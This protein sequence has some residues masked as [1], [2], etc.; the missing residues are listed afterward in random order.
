MTAPMADTREYLV[1][2]QCLRVTLD[3]FVDA[4]AR[5]DPS[6]LAL[7]LGSRWALFSRALHHHHEVEDVDFFPL[8]KRTRPEAS[9]MIDRLASEHVDLVA[10]LDAVDAGNIA[11]ELNPSETTKQIVH[12]CIKAVRDELVPHLD[13]EDAD[14]L[15][16]AAAAISADVWKEMGEKAFRSVPKKDLP[17]V[18]GVMDEIVR[19]LPIERRP[20]PPPLIVRVLIAVSWRKRYAKFIEPLVT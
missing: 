7:V 1:V 15:P 12:D 6:T 19:T 5:L 11:L 8:V 14:L 16:V 4:T 17:I 13:V 20:P 3:R 10:R 2:H 18:A 9:P